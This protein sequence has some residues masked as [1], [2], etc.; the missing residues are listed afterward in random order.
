MLICL[1]GFIY[2]VYQI[3]SIQ[4]LTG[5]SLK[6]TPPVRGVHMA[7]HQSYRPDRNNKFACLSDK[8]LISYD[9]VNDDYCDCQDGSDEPGTEACPNGQFYCTYETNHRHGE[10][11]I[12]FI[13]LILMY[14]LYYVR[15]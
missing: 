14:S 10:Y 12:N 11:T 5:A 13:I 6:T 15:L 7:L 4:E 3:K 9:K 2:T 8:K 1:V